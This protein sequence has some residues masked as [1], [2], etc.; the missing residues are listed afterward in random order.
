MKIY[1]VS[2]KLTLHVSYFQRYRLRNRNKTYFLGLTLDFTSKIQGPI[3]M[4]IPIVSPSYI[5][6]PCERMLTPPPRVSDQWDAEGP[7][8]ASA[9]EVR[10]PKDP[11]SGRV[12]LPHAP[13]GCTDDIASGALISCHAHLQPSR[14]HQC[15]ATAPAGKDPTSRKN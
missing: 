5:C 14:L 4:S 6:L 11:S 8:V 7:S 15:F 10:P 2:Y 1:S 13:S 3:L 12:G 9:M